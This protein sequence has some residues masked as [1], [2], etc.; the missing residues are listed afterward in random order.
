[1]M[2]NLYT[3]EKNSELNGDS[4]TQHFPTNQKNIVI[5]SAAVLHRSA[6]NFARNVRSAAAR[7]CC[8]VG[9]VFICLLLYSIRDTRYSITF[10]HNPFILRIEPMDAVEQRFREADETKEAERLMKTGN[11]SGARS[12]H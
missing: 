3:P 1:M 9:A 6:I 11:N 8:T 10:D 12:K 7:T 5:R 2:N 4:M